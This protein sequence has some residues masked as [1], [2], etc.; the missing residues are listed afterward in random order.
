MLER[1][2]IGGEATYAEEKPSPAVLLSL[3]RLILGSIGWSATARFTTVVGS[4]LR[5]ILFARLLT[6]YDF[7]IFGAALAVQTLLRQVTN[8]S[9][10]RALVPQP[11]NMERSLDTI[12]TA[13]VLQN[14]VVAVILVLGARR[15]APFLRVREWTVFIA[16]APLPILMACGTPAIVERIAVKFD[17]R[18]A[19][20]LNIGEQ[21]MGL[22][23]GLLAMLWWRD[24][25]ALVVAAY[26]AQIA[27]FG[28]AYHYYPYW[29]SFR[30]DLQRASALF[31]F[32]RWVMARK[33]ARYVADNLD[34]LVIA[35]LLGPSSLGS[36]QVAKRVAKLPTF[37][38]SQPVAD[39]AF[40]LGAR[41][42]RDRANGIRFLLL[43]NGA[44]I[45]IGVV[46]AM[47]IAKWGMSIVVVLVG[48]K[49]I[50][51]VAPLEFLCLFGAGQALL[52]IGIQFL[53]GANAPRAGFWVSMVNLVVLS[54]LILPLT[55]AFQA[56]G[57]AMAMFFS[58]A[59]CVPLIV[60]AYDRALSEG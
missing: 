54:I 44:A 19:C 3:P 21:T 48:R 18:T 33:I 11:E 17:F 57:T 9:L 20:I 47:V 1:L 50:G 40:P 2:E 55:H 15:L 58:M 22:G 42:R 29:P 4:A 27:Q 39:V 5:S 8:P 6:P 12:W 13:L 60:I 35:H 41:I 30:F 25:R 31:S 46:Y 26:A 34:S 56:T 43:T 59:A 52:A 10:S 7:G 51:A 36:Y 16:L 28:L 37:E 49:W 24:W 32:G 14:I 45:A 23:M 38:A 53:D